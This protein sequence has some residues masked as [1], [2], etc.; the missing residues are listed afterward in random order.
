MAG[1]GLRWEDPSLFRT[2]P[3]APQRI[4]A[5]VAT[6]T[7]FFKDRAIAEM[8]HNA[9]W[10]DRT[11]NARNGLDAAVEHVPFRR[12]TIILFHRV[13]YGIWLEVRAGG[14]NAILMPTALKVGPQLL[15]MI[16]RGWGPAV[17]GRGR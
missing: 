13:K 11:G 8:R 5:M 9:P 16:G 10:T 4:D 2:A 14:K 1:S 15:D 17:S 12:H 3:G 7:E 6:T